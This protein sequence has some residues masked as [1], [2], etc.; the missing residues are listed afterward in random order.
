MAIINSLENVANA[1]ADGVTAISNTVTTL[2]QLPPTLLKSV[3][4]TVGAKVGDAL[5]Y[6]VVITNLNLSPINA[7][8][9]TDPL[10]AG[11]EYVNGSFKLNSATHAA[12][13]NSET[14]TLTANLSSLAAL[15]VATVTFQVTIVESEASD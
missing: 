11:C 12:T 1:L 5:T 2:L 6:T 14:N 8:T 7:L 15:G 13:Y 4:I 10:P 9:F 3:D